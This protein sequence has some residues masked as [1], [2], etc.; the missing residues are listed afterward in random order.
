MGIDIGIF[1]VCFVIEQVESQ[2]SG[3]T[4]FYWK[5]TIFDDVLFFSSE[6]TEI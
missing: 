2:L 4:H 3:L 6:T 1:S 5:L